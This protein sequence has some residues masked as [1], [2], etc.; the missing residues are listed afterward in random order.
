MSILGSFGRSKGQG[1]RVISVPEA[2]IA[3]ILG[4]DTIQLRQSIVFLEWR[5]SADSRAKMPAQFLYECRDGE[6]GLRF[7]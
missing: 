4:R 3:G 6:R 1:A 5:V 7:V 2:C